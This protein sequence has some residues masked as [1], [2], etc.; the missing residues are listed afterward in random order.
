M[1]NFT[2]RQKV[3][4]WYT[5]MLILMA[6][7]VFFILQFANT[8]QT[9]AYAQE[10]LEKAAA[11]AQDEIDYDDGEIEIDRDIEKIDS[12]TLMV[13]DA[14][15]RALLYGPIPDFDLSLQEGS[16]RQVTGDSG[17]VWSV[18]D[19][20]LHL[21]GGSSVW[22]R[23]CLTL[24]PVTAIEQHALPLFWW[25]ILPIVLLAA[26]GGFYITS[27][28]FRPMLQ[29]SHTARSIADGSD[30]SRRI[31]L[32]SR[33]DEFG[34]LSS[35]FDD[36]FARLQD[37]FER[38]KQFTSDVSH[39]LRTPLSVIL[40]QCGYALTHEKESRNAL[41]AIQ[42]QAQRMSGL[43]NQLLF[44]SR[45]DRGT[46]ALHTEPVDLSE[47]MEATAQ[48]MSAKAESAGIRVLTDIEPSIFVTADELLLM[49]MLI[50]LAENA[51]RFGRS[52]GFVKFTLHTEDGQVHGTVEDDGIG[53]APAD[54][55]HVWERFYQADQSR[56]K[57]HSDGSSGLG[58]P[59]VKWIV[60]AHHGTIHAESM[61]GR[62]S[63]FSFTLPLRSA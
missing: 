45:A 54:L 25:M 19:V 1:K 51:I 7:A 52:G 27:R 41:L 44:L 4:F 9:E 47:L 2:V 10:A 13:Y 48:E 16:V 62:G 40:T 34:E 36:M 24:D 55:P 6:A 38:E 46:Q 5:A 50:N 30:L 28:A 11:D 23:A 31:G 43:V 8:R 56:H 17:R 18:Y 21:S 3:G 39:E 37:S 42:Q 20:S 35:T 12:A 63:V 32:S 26:L 61:P 59:M 15:G 58:L 49:R 33:K 22:V 57:R 53:I 14:D 60:A 29:I